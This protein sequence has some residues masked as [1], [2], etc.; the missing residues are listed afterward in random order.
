MY[1]LYQLSRDCMHHIGRLML[2]GKVCV[3]GGMCLYVSCGDVCLFRLRLRIM[4]TP[5]TIF[6][7]L[8]LVDN[9]DAMFV[10]L[11]LQVYNMGV[12]VLE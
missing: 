2:G 9:K 11:I 7:R 4:W 12:N 8:M 1:I 3:G 5:C 10:R 6:G